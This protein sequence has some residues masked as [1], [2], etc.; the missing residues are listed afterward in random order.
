MK[1]CATG[2]AHMDAE[3]WFMEWRKDCDAVKVHRLRLQKLKE[4]NQ[5]AFYFIANMTGT[6]RERTCTTF[7]SST[8][9]WTNPCTD[10]PPDAQPNFIQTHTHCPSSQSSGGPLTTICK[11]SKLFFNPSSFLSFRLPSLTHSSD[12]WV[13]RLSCVQPTVL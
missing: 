8:C 2:F 9:F 13:S 4:W 12:W 10:R 5:L 11:Q 1:T 7:P 3:Q 6:D